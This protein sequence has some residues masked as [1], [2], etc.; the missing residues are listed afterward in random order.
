[1][2]SIATWVQKNSLTVAIEK[3]AFDQVSFV[4]EGQ[5]VRVLEITQGQWRYPSL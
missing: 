4:E 2:P 3:E 1:M 5:P